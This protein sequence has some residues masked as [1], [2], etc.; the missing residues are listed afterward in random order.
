MTLPH[1]FFFLFFSNKV[2]SYYLNL[3]YNENTVQH[4]SYIQTWQINTLNKSLSWERPGRHVLSRKTMLVFLT[5][6]A[7]EKHWK[8][9][10]INTSG[11][12]GERKLSLN[13]TFE[14]LLCILVSQ[15]NFKRRQNTCNIKWPTGNFL[16]WKWNNFTA[17]K[18][19]RQ[20]HAWNITKLNSYYVTLCLIV[21]APLQQ[22]RNWQSTK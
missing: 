10:I 19:F 16:I 8:R 13:W 3:K 12:E 5:V 17:P 11:M 15:V 14:V 9:I 4:Y 22:M 1:S 2:N 18:L 6:C 21:N 20:L 7:T